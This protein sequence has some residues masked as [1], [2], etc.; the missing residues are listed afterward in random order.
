MIILLD[1]RLYLLYETIMTS[2]QFLSGKGIDDNRPASHSPS[3]A[4]YI[5]LSPDLFFHFDTADEVNPRLWP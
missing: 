5:L 3:E 1:T 2:S 4:E